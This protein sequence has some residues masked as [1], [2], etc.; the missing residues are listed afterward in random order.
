MY[1][2]RVNKSYLVFAAICCISPMSLWWRTQSA[3]GW[4]CSVPATDSNKLN[5]LIKKAGSVLGTDVDPLQLIL[6]K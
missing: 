4:G 2:K 3:C 1:K 5:K 6:Q